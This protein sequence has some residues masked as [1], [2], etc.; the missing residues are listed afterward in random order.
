MYS[1]VVHFFDKTLMRATLDMIFTFQVTVKEQ[2]QVKHH[3]INILDPL[4]TNNVVD[5]R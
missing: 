3:I 4:D 5:F 1:T 2:E